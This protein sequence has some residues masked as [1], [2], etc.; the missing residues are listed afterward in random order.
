MCYELGPID[1]GLNSLDVVAT[2]VCVEDNQDWI[3]H[4]HSTVL[5]KQHLH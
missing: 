4:N 2:Y 3:G 5:R 1:K